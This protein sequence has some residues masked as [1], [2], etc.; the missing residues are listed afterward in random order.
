VHIWNRVYSIGIAT[1]EMEPLM[2]TTFK[3][4]DVENWRQFAN[5]SIEI[6]PRLTVLTGANGAGKSTLLALLARHF[7]WSRPLLST[8][9]RDKDGSITFLTGAMEFL[10]AFFTKKES[11]NAQIGSIAYEDSSVASL[12]VPTTSGVEYQIDIRGQ[13]EVRG[14]SIPSHRVLS[15]YQTIGSIPTSGISPQQAF[16]NYSSEILARYQGG[17]T[18]H[19]PFF[20]MKE[21]LISMATFG[22]G[23]KYV[24]G[25]PELLTSYLGFISVLKKVLPPSL[26]FQTIEIRTP[27]VVLVTGTGEFLIDSVSGGLSALIDLAW[28]IHSYS[29]LGTDF[30][31]VIDE[32]ENHLHPSMQRA[33]MP[34]LLDAFPTVQFVVATHSP[35]VVTAVKESNVYVLNYGDTTM[36]AELHTFA[37]ERSVHAIKLDQVNKAGTA[38]EILR[39]VLGL[40]TTMPLWASRELDD[41]VRRYRTMPFTGEV[42]A[43]LNAELENIGL[44]ESLP[45]AV[46]AVR[47]Q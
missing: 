13:R 44:A 43:R 41:I 6:H 1:L 46:F 10:R 34:S 16:S 28:Q 18:G 17:N 3:R 12:W 4:I 24:K 9:W 42:I 25:K 20:R 37:P 14:L 22:E 5:V 21:A 35:F 40:D 30:V 15:H 45:S 26:G 32:P 31:V 19:S 33:L 7:G 23:N 38:N 8:P 27:D 29:S 47:N 39:N 2:G 36:S 11:S